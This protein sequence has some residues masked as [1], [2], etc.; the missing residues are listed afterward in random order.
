MIELKVKY[1]DA[2]IFIDEVEYG[3]IGNITVS[4]IV[5]QGSNPC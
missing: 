4:K 1:T 5:V 2:K 3:V